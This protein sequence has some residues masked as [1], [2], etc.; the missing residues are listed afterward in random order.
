MDSG[1]VETVKKALATATAKDPTA[2]PRTSRRQR[3]RSERG[4][5]MG[6]QQ[7]VHIPARS[8]GRAAT[9]HRVAGVSVIYVPQFRRRH[10]QE[11]LRQNY[12]TIADLPLEVWSYVMRQSISDGSDR[13][14]DNADRDHASPER[15]L[16]RYSSS[17]TSET[18]QLF[19][20][21]RRRR[22]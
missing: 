2:R 7:A 13:R 3:G 22:R 12:P 16:R 14:T 11:F 6:E 20:S 21:G 5:V 17:K 1:K 18:G 8:I 19:D 15:S 4:F 9:H 10:E